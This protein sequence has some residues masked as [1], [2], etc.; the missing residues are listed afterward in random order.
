MDLWFWLLLLASQNNQPQRIPTPEEAKSIRRGNIIFCVIMLIISFIPLTLSAYDDYNKS[1]QVNQVVRAEWNKKQI[2]DRELETQAQ[3][4]R[5]KQFDIEVAESQRQYQMDMQK[6]NERMQPILTNWD[7]IGQPSQETQQYSPPQQQQSFEEGL[8]ALNITP[9]QNYQPPVAENTSPVIVEYQAPIV[10][11]VEVTVK[12][13]STGA[14][15]K[16]GGYYL[17][18][19]SNENGRSD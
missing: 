14:I 19:Y 2:R 10:H 18:S 1:N 3:A 9:I 5:S 4:E 16:A 13:I 7:K 17:E 15:T 8:K 6:E 11:R 12:D